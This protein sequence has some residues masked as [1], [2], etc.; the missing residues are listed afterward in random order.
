MGKGKKKGG[1]KRKVLAALNSQRR[2]KIRIFENAFKYKVKMAYYYYYYY[3]FKKLIL[4][5]KCA[6]ELAHF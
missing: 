6:Q 5:T 4:S 1:F 3:F 2:K